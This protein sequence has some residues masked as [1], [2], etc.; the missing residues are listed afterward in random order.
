MWHATY[1]M[2]RL[3]NAVRDSCRACVDTKARER[4]DHLQKQFDKL[5]LVACT[6]AKVAFTGL[7]KQWLTLSQLLCNQDPPTSGSRAVESEGAVL[8][9]CTANSV[10]VN[11]RPVWGNGANEFTYICVLL[12]ARQLRQGKGRRISVRI[13]RAL[14]QSERSR[15]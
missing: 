6:L 15:T 3:V 8:S 10:V 2:A 12:F 9:E 13:Y 1:G 4:L 14:K 5:Q 7:A 11:I